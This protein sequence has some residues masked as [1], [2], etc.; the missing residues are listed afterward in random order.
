MY[1]PLR[2]FLTLAFVLFV[3]G[4]IPILRFLY[5][6]LIGEG[7]GHIQ[8]L[9]VGGLLVHMGFLSLMI[10]VVVDLISF[11]RQLSERTLEIVRRMELNSTTA[12]N[13]PGSGNEASAAGRTGRSL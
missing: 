5:L 4:I 9:V 7:Q 10:G 12:T 3:I 13:P 1:Q 2:I 11:N 8:S 6:Y